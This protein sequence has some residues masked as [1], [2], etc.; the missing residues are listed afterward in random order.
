MYEDIIEAVLDYF[1]VNSEEEVYNNYGLNDFLKMA[2][3][4]VI[5]Y[6]EAIAIGL[7]DVEDVIDK[8][9]V[10]KCYEEGL[11]SQAEAISEGMIF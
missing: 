11:I 4:D 5:S 3:E 6:D 9:G 8:I 10:T 2:E 1:E 7:L